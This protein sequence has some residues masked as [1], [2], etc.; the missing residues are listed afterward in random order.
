[1]KVKVFLRE[2]IVCIVFQLH[3][4]RK[5]KL[6]LFLSTFTK[7]MQVCHINVAKNKQNT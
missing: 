6:F 1:M 4:E 5:Y 7:D 2:W 3:L